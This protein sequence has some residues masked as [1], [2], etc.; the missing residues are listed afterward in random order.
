MTDVWVLPASLR[1]RRENAH[2]KNDKGQTEQGWSPV[3]PDPM[4]VNE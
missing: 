3:G 1:E 2:G 4:V